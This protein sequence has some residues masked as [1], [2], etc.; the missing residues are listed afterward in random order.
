MYG[1]PIKNLKRWILL[2]TERKKGKHF[3][4]EEVEGK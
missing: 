2:G 3:L 4:Y 1:I